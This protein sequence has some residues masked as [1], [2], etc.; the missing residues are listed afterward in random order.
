[1]LLLFLEG[2]LCLLPWVYSFDAHNYTIGGLAVCLKAGCY[3]RIH[4]LSTT[5]C[6][7]LSN[8]CPQVT[9]FIKD[10]EMNHVDIVTSLIKDGEMNN[11]VKLLRLSFST[12]M[13]MLVSVQV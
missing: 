10:G 7:K 4:G 12:S 2:C 5:G 9:S 11:I 13:I 8:P 1:M 6:S 3:C